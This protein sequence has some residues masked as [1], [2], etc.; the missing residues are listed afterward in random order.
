M[1][2]IMAYHTITISNVN[3]TEKE[4]AEV[5]NRLSAYDVFLESSDGKSISSYGISDTKI[6][7]SIDCGAMVNELKAYLLAVNHYLGDYC[8]LVQIKIL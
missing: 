8:K 5:R 1:I 6:V 2:D 3:L 7:Y 4:F